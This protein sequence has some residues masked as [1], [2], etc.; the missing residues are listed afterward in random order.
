M[1]AKILTPTLYK[2][3]VLLS[4]V[5]YGLTPFEIVACGLPPEAI[6]QGL[7]S[8]NMSH[9]TAG[10]TGPLKAPTPKDFLHLH[11]KGF[12]AV[13]RGYAT[14]NA[15]CPIPHNKG[16]GVCYHPM[17]PRGGLSEQQ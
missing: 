1:Q 13:L 6:M 2:V 8:H 17:N 4:P 10:H 7:H 14:K 16:S 11:F 15:P 9:P 12:L 3:A 5:S